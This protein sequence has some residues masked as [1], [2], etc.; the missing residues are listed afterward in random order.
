ME[1]P[2]GYRGT[3]TVRA[4]GGRILVTERET[5][6]TLDIKG[7]LADLRSLAAGGGR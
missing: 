2:E 7:S 4:E 5:K 1:I 3:E 6:R